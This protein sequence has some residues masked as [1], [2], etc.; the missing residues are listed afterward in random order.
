MTNKTDV[1]DLLL[2]EEL[3]LRDYQVMRVPGGWIY[4]NLLWNFK[5]GA[6]I[7]SFPVFVPFV[8]K[9]V[10][11]PKETIDEP[12]PYD[13]STVADIRKGSLDK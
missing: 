12:N 11:K 2:H 3:T 9:P 8:E 7:G 4:T 1:Y 13:L 5:R 6:G 10:E